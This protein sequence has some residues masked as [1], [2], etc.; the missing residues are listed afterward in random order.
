MERET[1]VVIIWILLVAF[2]AMFS[3]W[4]GGIAS[5]VIILGLIYFKI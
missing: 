2:I 4:E 1:K 5:I 3:N